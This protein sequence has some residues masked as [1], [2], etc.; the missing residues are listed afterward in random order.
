MVTYAQI[1]E[2]SRFLEAQR[3]LPFAER[4]RVRS[5]KHIL[6]ILS[7]DEAGLSSHPEHEASWPNL[8]RFARLLN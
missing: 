5:V 8:F 7:Y 1:K 3:K 6:T 4:V 2:V